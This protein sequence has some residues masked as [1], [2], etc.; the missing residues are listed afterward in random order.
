MFSRSA[1]LAETYSCEHRA[2]SRA[3]SGPALRALGEGRVVHGLA[4]TG[5]RGT[6]AEASARGR[7]GHWPRL[8]SHR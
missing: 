3:S 2:G 7:L 5:R 8:A 4:A 6:G 1:C